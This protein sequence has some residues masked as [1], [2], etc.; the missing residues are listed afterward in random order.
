MD[1]DQLLSKRNKEINDLL[2]KLQ[3]KEIVIKERD[4]RI[5]QLE[6]QLIELQIEKLNKG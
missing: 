4:I 1:T 6:Q 2:Y 3:E 5:L